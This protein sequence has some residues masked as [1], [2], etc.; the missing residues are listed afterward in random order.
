MATAPG[1]G[2]D[3]SGGA[4]DTVKKAVTSSAVTKVQVIGGC[5][6]VSIGTSLAPTAKADGVKIC[7]EAAKVAYTGNVMAVSVDG[8]DGH[9]LSAG[10]KGAPCV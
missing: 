10:I 2:G 9:E 3:C 4:A 5:T 1:D 8:S 7:E 6:E